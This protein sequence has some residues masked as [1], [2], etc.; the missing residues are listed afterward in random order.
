MSRSLWTVPVSPDWT[1]PLNDAYAELHVIPQGRGYDLPLTMPPGLSSDSPP[2]VIRVRW[3]RPHG[4]TAYEAGMLPM[5][6]DVTVRPR[7]QPGRS[8]RESADFAVPQSDE[9]DDIGLRKDLLDIFEN[10]FGAEFPYIDI[11]E[12]KRDLVT[13]GGSRFLLLSICGLSAREVFCVPAYA[14][15]LTG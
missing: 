3:F 8:A 7:Q 2:R 14:N 4:R 9:L 12:L 10:R 15:P 5:S 1:L 6:L 13:G 11:A